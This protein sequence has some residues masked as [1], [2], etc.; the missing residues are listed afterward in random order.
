VAPFLLFWNCTKEGL[1]IHRRR[2]SMPSACQQDETGSKFMRQSIR[3]ARVGLKVLSAA[4]FIAI[5]FAASAHADG[6]AA[7][8]KKVFAKCM[9]CHTLEAGKNKVGPSLHGI[10]GRKSGSVEGFT[11][12]DAMKNSNLT[13]DEAELDK[14]LTNP[15]KLVPGNKMAFP[16][17]PKPA[18][19]ANVIAYL[20]EASQ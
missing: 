12:S 3:A 15:K 14:Y 13:W 5:G 17:L 20:K 8:G 1:A 16:G 9:A 7:K 4:A 6:D 11:Y 18:D 10:I 2:G 19:R